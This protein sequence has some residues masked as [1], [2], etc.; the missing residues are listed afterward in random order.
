[1]KAVVEAGLV[2]IVSFPHNL[3]RLGLRLPLRWGQVVRGIQPQAGLAHLVVILSFQ[4]T[5]LLV[6][7]VEVQPLMEEITQEP[8]VDQVAVV[9]IVVLVALV[10]HL[11]NHHHK[12]ITA[13]QEVAHQPL[14]LVAVEVLEQ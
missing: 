8:Q 6:A 12:V 1:M 7:V 11:H 10:T 5:L 14:I 4:L 2:V 9:N 13:A 3:Y